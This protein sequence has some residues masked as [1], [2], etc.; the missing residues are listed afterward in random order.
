MVKLDRKKRMQRPRA[1]AQVKLLYQSN[2][3]PHKKSLKKRWKCYH[4]RV[5]YNVKKSISIGYFP[6]IS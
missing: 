2:P 1:L 5:S 4:V 6:S 3:V